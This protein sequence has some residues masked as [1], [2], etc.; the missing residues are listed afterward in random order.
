MSGRPFVTKED[1]ALVKKLAGIER[2]LTDW[3]VEFVESI[4]EQIQRN[5]SLSPKQRACGERILE[6]LGL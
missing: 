3:E 5:R 6:R 1:H 4:A 2:G